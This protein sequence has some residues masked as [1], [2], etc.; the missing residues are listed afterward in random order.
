MTLRLLTV[1]LALSLARPA[2]AEPAAEHFIISMPAGS[3][4]EGFARQ[5]F[6]EAY[7]RLGIDVT[8]ALVPSARS[9]AMANEGA[10]DA[11]A[12]RTAEVGARFGNL[13][14][15]PSTII[16]M[17]YRAITR[18]RKLAV[19]GWDSLKGHRICSL[20][21]DKLIESR[22][23]GLDREMT[24][25]LPSALKM[26]EA[27]RCDVLIASQFAWSDFDTIAPG[28]YCESDAPLMSVPIYHYVNKRHADLVPALTRILD[29]MHQDGTSQ[30]FIAPLKSRLSSVKA[31]YGCELR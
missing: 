21:G 5:E 27:G 29:S 16:E 24:R 12:G 9:L 7:H 28:H 14:R 11:D 19:T 26:L 17:D 25:G 20:L 15:V 4:L 10:S 8:F 18:D 22:T 3:P 6:S 1:L 31:R 30:R 23:A 13:V 2:F